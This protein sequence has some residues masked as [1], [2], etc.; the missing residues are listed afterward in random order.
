[1]LRSAMA[2]QEQCCVKEECGDDNI[3]ECTVKTEEYE[4]SIDTITNEDIAVQLKEED[5]EQKVSEETPKN[6]EYNE[7]TT[8]R[9]FQRVLV[10]TEVTG[11]HIRERSHISAFSVGR[12]LRFPAP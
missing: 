1:M 6:T 12:G 10:L 8:N 5:E 9:S 4:T 2:F 11:E 7:E 3:T